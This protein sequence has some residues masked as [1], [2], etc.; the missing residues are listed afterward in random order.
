MSSS[1]TKRRSRTP[2][3]TIRFEDKETLQRIV[4]SV[5]NVVERTT[6]K[7][8]RVKNIFFL[9][10]DTQD[11]SGF[12]YVSVRYKL[13]SCVD[14]VGEEQE[15]E[16]IRFCVDCRHFS[17]ILV[18]AP[19]HHVIWLEGHEQEAA[20]KVIV[21]TKDVDQPTHATVSELDTFIDAPV[22]VLR[23]LEFD[24]NLELD[25]F[26]FKNLL[27]VANNARAET[28]RIRIFVEEGSSSRANPTSYVTFT[29]HGDWKHTQVFCHEVVKG[30]DG[31]MVVRAAPDGAVQED[32]DGGREAMEEEGKEAAYE[33]V[34]PLEKISGFVKLI[35]TR[36]LVAK[37]KPGK[38]MM[39]H[40]VLGGS[41][42]DQ[43]HIKF[44]VAE[45]TPE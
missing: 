15:Q 5:L 18:N 3:W 33:A 34:F 13:D 7:V 2:D 29:V 43:S 14:L 25:L 10:V 17:S 19:A 32:D 21:R 41:V 6:F 22:T 20:P 26:V 28:L 11:V 24:M 42:A 4:N 37:L 12:V 23:G 35:S 16:G 1:T 30:E 45:K 39:F 27:K 36:M 40:H 9:K 44:L 38:P 31:S 8:E